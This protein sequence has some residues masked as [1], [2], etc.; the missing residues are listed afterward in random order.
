VPS[1]DR[2]AVSFIEVKSIETKLRGGYRAGATFTPTSAEQQ[3]LR[4]QVAGA[5]EVT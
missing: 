2:I 5:E 3:F 4:E 1:R